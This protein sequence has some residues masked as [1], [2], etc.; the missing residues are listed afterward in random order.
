MNESIRVGLSDFPEEE[1]KCRQ[2]FVD[3]TDKGVLQTEDWNSFAIGA[4]AIKKNP[5]DLVYYQS[6]TKKLHDDFISDPTT[7][8]LELLSYSRARLFG[9][10]AMSAVLG[11]EN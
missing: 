9:A 8:G 2:R 5:T 3:L 1:E 7:A 6:N 4:M 11:G 10:E